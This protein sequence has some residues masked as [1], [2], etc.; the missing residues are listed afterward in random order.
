MLIIYFSLP[1]L[2]P[3]L[4]RQPAATLLFKKIKKDRRYSKKQT[5]SWATEFFIMVFKGTTMF[6]ASLFRNIRR[7]QGF[8]T[9]RQVM[10]CFLPLNWHFLEGR[11]VAGTP[12]WLIRLCRAWFVAVPT[13]ASY[14]GA[15][16][17]IKDQNFK[18]LLFFPHTCEEK[19]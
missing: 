2:E 15:L 7:F 1:A 14:A 18:N 13:R 6:S 19:N 4:C 8:R 5:T 11:G 12:A 3:D 10:S 9:I 16:H 17:A